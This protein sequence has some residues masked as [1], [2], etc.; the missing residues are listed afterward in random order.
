MRIVTVF[1]ATAMLLS[2]LADGAAA[3]C[4]PLKMIA[5]ITMTPAADKRQELVPVKVAGMPVQMLLDTGGVYSEIS[6]ATADELKL[7]VQTGNF[8]L[9]GVSGASTSLFTAATLE[10]GSLKADKAALVVDPG[11]SSSDKTRVGILAPDILRHYDVH[12]DFGENTLTLLSPDHCEGKVI[13]WPASA[14]A[15]VPMEVLESGHI[16]ITVV[17]D[18]KSV[19]AIIDT[20]AS[21]ST[22]TIPAAET[23][24]DLKLGSADTPESGELKPG[25]KTYKHTFK[26]LDFEGVAV[27]N[28]HVDI[29]PDMTHGIMEN[30]PAIGTRIAERKK[31]E[32][33]ADMLIGMDILRHFNLYIAYKE[34]KLYITPATTPAASASPAGAAQAKTP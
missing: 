6:G 14:V 8:D 4:G 18:G 15:V 3:D 26:T 5:S 10:I 20:G 11:L 27:G 22:L 34:Q 29:I 16:V 9:Y 25:S 33:K 13:Y 19:T 12:L 23:Y 2:L 30:R 31:D 17:L 1:L 21:G 32:N 24:F 28:I 7:P